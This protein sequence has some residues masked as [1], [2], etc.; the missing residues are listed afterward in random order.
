MKEKIRYFREQV[1]AKNGEHEQALFRIVFA[2]TI[3]VF[4]LYEYSID[5]SF[6][7]VFLFSGVWLALS[8]SIVFIVLIQHNSSR[9][10]QIIA[11]IADIGAVTYGMLTTQESGVILYGIY[12]WVIIGNGMRYGIPSL[13][14]SYVCS[15]L[16]FTGVII[17]NDYWQDHARVA[18]GLMLTLVFV[19]LYVIKLRNQLN[20]AL[21][22][23]VKA[24]QAKSMF[25]ANM[26]HEMRTPLNGVIGVSNLLGDSKLNEEQKDLVSMLKNSAQLLL[27]LIDNVLDLSK[28]ESGK[29]TLISEP[30][31]LHEL[32]SNSH[33]ILAQQAEVKGLKFHFR[34]APELVD[35]VRG[36]TL[37]LRQVLT[38]LLGNAIKFTHKGVVEL[39]VSTVHQDATHARIK[40]EVID[41]G[42]G[43]SAKAQQHIFDSFTQADESIT[44]SYGGTGLGTTISKHLVELMGGEMGLHSEVGIGSVFW[45]ELPF[46]KQTAQ[47]ESVAPN[48]SV[49]KPSYDLSHLHVITLGMKLADKSSITNCLAEW[50]V[51]FE[52]ESTLANFFAQLVTNQVNPPGQLVVLCAP[53]NV[54]MSAQEFAQHFRTEYPQKNVSLLL[55][56]PD[57]HKYSEKDFFD[58]GYDCLLKSPID[59]PLLYNAL[60]E[61]MNPPATEGVISFKEHYE[62]S[63]QEKR[64]INILV[65]DD[66]GTNLKVLSKILQRAGHSVDAV[67]NGEEALDQLEFKHYDL[68]IL[69]MHMPDLGGLEV[70]KIHRATHLHDS[71]PVMILTANAMV[72]AQRE[73]ETAGIES[74]MTKPFDPLVLLDTIA[75]LTSSSTAQADIPIVKPRPVRVENTVGEQIVNQ[76]TLRHLSLLGEGNEEFLQTVVFGFLA[77]T[78]IL[79]EAMQ[80]AL[81]KRE[82]LAFKDIAHA[83]KGGAGNVGAES[84]E[85]ICRSIMLLNPVSLQS[86][87]QDVLHQAQVCFKSTK[88]LLKQAVNT[89]Q[90]ASH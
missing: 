11:M 45:F 21:Q 59:K 17:F 4:L 8:F 65:A 58:A 32:L 67:T 54:G 46:E 19:P 31:S 53:Q 42:I 16:G 71:T 5:S 56:N 72:E 37:H 50:S 86:S 18:T 76:N 3:F 28:I 27:R 62:R 1:Q 64:G 2:T 60:H 25:V 47:V 84:L 40:F 77:E 13:M 90:A 12:L 48:T 22:S 49:T 30:F 39:R 23:A 63:S 88:V 33:K 79:L 68:M 10:R 44:R 75:R 85:K 83:I 35:T 89:A 36:D 26:S 80:T 82:Y 34:M 38:N 6:K 9:T 78:E 87:A 70:V 41:T 73:C 74:Y 57:L 24:N 51:P 14:S 29:I 20:Q 43:I 61:V 52:H 55:L 81:L 66:N 7:A 15:I 69:D